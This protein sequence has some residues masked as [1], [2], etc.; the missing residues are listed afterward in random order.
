M[1]CFVLIW[2]QYLQDVYGFIY[3]FTN[4]RPPCSA[5]MYLPNIDLTDETS[6]QSHESDINFSLHMA[7]TV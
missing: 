4:S 7:E 1:M 3:S 2:G 6:T 5:Y